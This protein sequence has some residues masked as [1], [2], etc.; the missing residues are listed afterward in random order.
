[1]VYRKSG[2]LQMTFLIAMIY[3]T[4][5]STLFTIAYRMLVVTAKKTVY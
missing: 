1:M 5:I 3:L 2:H 4:G